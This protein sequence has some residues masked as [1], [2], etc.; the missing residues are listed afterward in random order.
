LKQAK[1]YSIPKHIIK[2]AINKAKGSNNKNFNKLHYK[3]FKPAKT[4]LII[5][6]LTNNVNH[7]AS[8]IHAAFNKNNKNMGVNGSVA[9]MF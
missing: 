8:N 7:T 1:T 6:A 3:G 5:N 9:Y 4:M 2:K